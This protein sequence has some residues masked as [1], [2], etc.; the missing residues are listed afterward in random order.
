MVK[1]NIHIGSH[2]QTVVIIDGIANG[3]YRQ[4]ILWDVKQKWQKTE[5]TR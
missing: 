1:D 3:R 4:K 5:P 2:G